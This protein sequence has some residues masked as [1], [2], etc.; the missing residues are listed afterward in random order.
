MLLHQSRSRRLGLLLVTLLTGCM[1]TPV[2][3]PI[4]IHEE[5][6]RLSS[7][8]AKGVVVAVGLS[9]AATGAE[10]IIITNLETSIIQQGE[11][12]SAGTFAVA[13]SA[14]VSDRLEL[15]AKAG[16]FVSAGR[17][18]TIPAPAGVPAPAGWV[19]T[20]DKTGRVTASGTVRSGDRV[21]ISLPRTGDVVATTGGTGG[22]FSASLQAVLG[23]ELMLVAV[24]NQARGSEHLVLTVSK[25]TIPPACTDLD[26]DGYGAAGTDLTNCSGSS[27]QADCDDSSKLAFPKQP[28]FFTT[29][30]PGTVSDYDYNCDGKEQ[31]E[32]DATSSCSATTCSNHGWQTSVPACGQAGTWVQ[33]VMVKTCTEQL[34]A[35]TQACR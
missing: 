32:H 21:L 5:H 15:A 27:S 10:Q 17:Q 25:Q 30:I 6:M 3:V 33:C 11:V 12:T 7:P 34:Q 8:D 24:D 18:I 19:S 1:G 20:P 35:R 22:A 9:G 2:P 26:G 29:P 23:D 13:V 28:L 31:Q 14:S 16:A 4:P